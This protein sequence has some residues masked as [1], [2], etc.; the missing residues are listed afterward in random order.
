LHGGTVEARSDGAGQGSTF[1]ARIPLAAGCDDRPEV[2]LPASD[3]ALQARSRRILVVDDNIDSA[4]SLSL[5]LRAC[6]HDVTQAYTGQAGIAAALAFPPDM[7]ILDIGLPDMTGY[8][9]A[10]RLRA[11]APTAHTVLVALSGWGQSVDRQRS[12][13]A[14]CRAARPDARH[15]P[16]WPLTAAPASRP[17]G[18]RTRPSSAVLPPGT[19]ETAAARRA[20]GS[21]RSGTA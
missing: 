14:S 6:G 18:W 11:E 4:D 1:I 16:A 12:A 20:R 5:L 9:V 15:R 7:A 2:A 21:R 10:S 8:D 19:A 17:G 13:H 3:A